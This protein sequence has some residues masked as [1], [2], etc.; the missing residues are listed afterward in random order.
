MSLASRG[1]PGHAKF[2]QSPETPSRPG[3]IWAGNSLSQVPEHEYLG[4][5]NS[6]LC[7]KGVQLLEG[8]GRYLFK[9]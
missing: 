1:R 8:Q 4:P 3:A 7:E 9:H 2:A 6:L 5:K